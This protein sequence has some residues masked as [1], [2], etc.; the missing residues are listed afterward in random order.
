MHSNTKL[1][2]IQVSIILNLT[3]LVCV[4][5]TAVF[6]LSKQYISTTLGVEYSAPVSDDTFTYTLSQDG[7]SYILTHIEVGNDGNII[8]PKTYNNKPV[9]SIADNLLKDNQVV[10]KFVM[11]SNITSIGN[12]A[13]QNCK[14]LSTITIGENTTN[15]YTDTFINCLSIGACSFEGCV[16]L[17]EVILANDVQNIGWRSFAFCE[18][19]K[20][21][22]LGNNL[23]DVGTS[24]FDSCLRLQSITIGSNVQHIGDWAFSYSFKIVEVIN[25]SQLPISAGDY[26][27]PTD[28]IIYN[29]TQPSKQVLHTDENG[30]VYFEYETN[31]YK[32]YDYVGTSPIVIIPST[33]N[34][35]NITEIRDQ[36]FYNN[37]YITNITIGN[38][39]NNIG[40]SVFF[41]CTNIN[42][43]IIEDINNWA[44]INFE[45]SSS[46]PICASIYAQLYL[47]INTDDPLINIT[48]TNTTKISNYAFYGYEQLITASI[49]NSVTSIG[50]Q[51]FHICENINS[52]TFENPS[53]WYISDSSLA[54]S[55]K[56]ITSADLT[57]LTTA[58][59]YLSSEYSSYYWFRST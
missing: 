34:E 27:I 13:F 45:E 22:V 9:K 36:A 49:G 48:L 47:S 35:F 39:I 43:V 28:A 14:N 55:G 10:K 2:I 41:G 24:A 4:S 32:V 38:N 42:K 18:N 26:N 15:I 1:K 23:I 56:N 25:L 17:T 29:N 6:G 51:A 3:L 33:Y 46:N 20:K 54:S 31:K 12:Y 5:I 19:I 59:S 37:D 57:N 52:I 50:Y 53:N 16:G 40:K 7:E 21:V 44:Q 58:A 8:V 30:I 11:Q